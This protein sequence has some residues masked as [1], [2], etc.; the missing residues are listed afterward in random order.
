MPTQD[1]IRTLVPLAAADLTTNDLVPVFHAASNTVR[2]IPAKD[3]SNT[4]MVISGYKEAIQ[5]LG[6]LGASTT[7]TQAQMEAASIFTA[8]VTRNC[9]ISLPVF[10]S[11]SGNPPIYEAGRTITLQLLCDG[12]PRNV[13]ILNGF[14]EG[15]LSAGRLDPATLQISSVNP[16]V[17]KVLTFGSSPL[18]ATWSLKAEPPTDI[19]PTD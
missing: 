15:E 8:Y 2:K 14:W 17:C 4:N 5:D 1:D 18:E 9:N 6:T 11:G 12:T 3:L 10:N 7:I 16:I 13:S 19:S